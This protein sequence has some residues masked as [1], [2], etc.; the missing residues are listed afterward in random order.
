MNDDYF[1]PFSRENILLNLVLT[2]VVIGGGILI[3][4]YFTQKMEREMEDV[5]TKTNE[6]IEKTK[7]LFD[8]FKD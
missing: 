4:R 3:D 1:T 8:N 7:N 6:A 5:R 2:G